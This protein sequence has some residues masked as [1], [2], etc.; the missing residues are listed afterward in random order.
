M[1]Y[2]TIDIKLASMGWVQYALDLFGS[3]KMS[4]DFVPAKF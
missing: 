3:P 1:L 4:T 2:H